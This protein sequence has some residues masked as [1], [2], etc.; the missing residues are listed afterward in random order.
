MVKINFE[1]PPVRNILERIPSQYSLTLRSQIKLCVLL[2][3]KKEWSIQSNTGSVL[4]HQIVIH[5][6]YK[7]R[8]FVLTNL[9][10]IT[11]SAS[12]ILN[13]NIFR[14]KGQANA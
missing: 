13:F 1:H 3:S 2:D 12:L 9:L 8:N 11:T 14:I 4:S 10:C 7:H 6:I 5:D